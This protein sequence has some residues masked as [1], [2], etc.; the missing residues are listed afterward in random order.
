MLLYSHPCSLPF[1]WWDWLSDWPWGVHT[2]ML[3]RPYSPLKK[4]R[5]IGGTPWGA[6]NRAMPRSTHLGPFLTLD[7]VTRKFTGRYGARTLSPTVPCSLCIK[8]GACF[9]V[10]TTLNFLRLLFGGPSR[11]CHRCDIIKFCMISSLYPPLE[12][13]SSGNRGSN[14]LQQ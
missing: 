11:V 1:N 10:K 6:A 7:T 3:P 8:I 4:S 2:C 12:L 14:S 13:K 5:W 9:F